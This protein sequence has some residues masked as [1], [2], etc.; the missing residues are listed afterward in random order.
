MHNLT[1][2]RMLLED[3]NDIPQLVKVF[4]LPEVAQYLSI[5]DNYFHYVTNSENV[6]FFKVYENSRMIG[7]IHI[8]KHGAVLYMD[9]LVFPE[10]QKR[11]LGTCIIKDI[12]HGIFGLSYERIEVS[13]DERNTASL[14]LFKN[15]GF[16]CTSKNDELIDF[17]Y[18]R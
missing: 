5:A 2:T 1:Y 11:G 16:I 8:E 10:Y 7:S 9:I 17:V 12:Q 15:A 18:Q 3:D 13:I 6:Y 14:R 4:T